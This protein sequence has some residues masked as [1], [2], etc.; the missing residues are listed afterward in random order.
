MLDEGLLIL[1][2]DL[3]VI[4]DFLCCIKG[5]NFVL[6]LFIGGVENFVVIDICK[7]GVGFGLVGCI[8]VML[9][10]GREINL[11]KLNFEL[12]NIM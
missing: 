9:V 5:L 3:F 10:D 12:C 4:D 1:D 8:F 2:N 11:I 6:N 7:V